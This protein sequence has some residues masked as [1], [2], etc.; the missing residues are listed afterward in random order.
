MAK[1]FSVKE[2]ALKLLEKAHDTYKGLSGPYP[3]D[4]R[5]FIQWFVQ[6]RGE[7]LTLSVARRDY[8]AYRRH[9]KKQGEA[10]EVI[11]RMVMSARILMEGVKL[12]RT[13]RQIHS[14]M[15]KEAQ[16][17]LGKKPAHIFN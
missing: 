12:H 9:L 3:G 11:D 2:D 16:E 5:K 7:A 15:R 6:H 14:D 4:M 1:V 17:N 10:P 8:L 13:F